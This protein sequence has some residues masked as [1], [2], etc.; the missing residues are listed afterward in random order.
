MGTLVFVGPAIQI[1]SMQ[2]ESK[3]P[4]SSCE[5][6]GFKTLVLNLKE[7]LKDLVKT[8]NEILLVN[9]N[10]LPYVYANKCFDRQISKKVGKAKDPGNIGYMNQF[11]IGW[12]CY[13][14]ELPD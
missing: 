4:V 3:Q 1:R 12:K 9:R 2:V 5:R 14:T 8:R 7:L 13:P 10:K 6:R 11:L